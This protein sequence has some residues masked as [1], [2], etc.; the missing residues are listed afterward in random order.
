LLWV[1]AV[2]ALLDFAP[3]MF[4]LGWIVLVGNRSNDGMGGA[5]LVLIAL[6][7]VCP[8]LAI[9]GT[10][11]WTSAWLLFRREAPGRTPILV[12]SA[13]EGAVGLSLWVLA[14][15]VRVWPIWTALCGFELYLVLSE[16]ARIYWSS[17]SSDSSASSTSATSG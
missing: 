17:A 15:S 7:T 14:P 2:K 3:G 10:F 5:A 1:E 11:H 12:V 13:I 4:L 8:V 6:F 9:V 16:R